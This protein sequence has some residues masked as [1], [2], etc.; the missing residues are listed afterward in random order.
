MQPYFRD[1][2]GGD[3]PAL[4]AILRGPAPGP[5]DTPT[6]VPSM[7][8]T[9]Y[10]DALAE[11]DASRGQ[12]L[13]VAEYDRQVIAVTQLI[14]F[15]QL[16]ER[17]ARIAQITSMHVADQFRF[18]EIGAMLLDHAAERA[19][20]L[21]CRRLQVRSSTAATREH[22]FWERTGFI[23]LDRGYVRPLA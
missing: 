5:D 15:R 23:Q 13:M 2:V 17:G 1:A 9:A 10:R 12:Y 16:D 11:I 22:S 8:L 3:L 21:G 20:E 4:A 14:T 19:I 6:G 18:T 7:S